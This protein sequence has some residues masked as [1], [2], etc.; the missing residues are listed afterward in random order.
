M[1]KN[2]RILI[3][4]L[5]ACA[6]LG[7]ALAGLS[8]AAQPKT[9]TRT[10]HA[11]RHKAAAKATVVKA[12]SAAAAAPA[13]AAAP[14]DSAQAAPVPAPSPQAE[15]AA[16]P[17]G[18]AG[19]LTIVAMPDVVKLLQQKAAIFIDARPA[20]QFVQGHIPGALNCYA[21]EFA[22]EFPKIQPQLPKDARIILY[23]DGVDCPMSHDLGE[24]M[25]PLGYTN[26]LQYKNGWDEW[27]AAKAPADS[28]LVTH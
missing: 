18:K 9:K 23:C 20:S 22:T 10:K 12:D 7:A 11:V 27:S 8:A 5:L 24:K 15:A 17:N 14:A 25:L 16:L 26:L 2:P 28:G 4:A 13:V 6:A 19:E 3:A 1:P 21:D